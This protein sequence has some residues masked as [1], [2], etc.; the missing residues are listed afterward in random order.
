MA[1]NNPDGQQLIE[2]ARSGCLATL[3]CDVTEG[4]FRSPI[5][6]V[7][8][9]GRSEPETF[10]LLH[11]H[12][13][14]WDYGIGDNAVGDATLLEVARVL[15]KHRDH[16]ERSVRIAWWPGHS[17]GRYAGSTWFADRFAI[18]LYENCIAQINCDSPGCRS[19]SVIADH[20]RCSNGPGCRSPAV[21]SSSRRMISS[22]FPQHSRSGG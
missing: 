3:T 7:T 11:G 1:V 16:L 2:Q 19:A 4:W 8:I 18:D 15:W 20:R 12:Y 17:T 21:C 10:V 5:P 9:P 13:D 22:M 14:S 6:V